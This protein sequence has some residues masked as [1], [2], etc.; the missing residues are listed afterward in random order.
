MKYG[1]LTIVEENIDYVMAK[2]DCGTTKSYKLGNLK[3]GHTKSCGCLN[4]E[5]QKEKRDNGV[6]KTRLYHIWQTMKARCSNPNSDRYKY[7]GARGISFCSE[8]KVFITFQKWAN[9]NG[10]SDNLTLDRTE[11]NSDYSPKNCRWVTLLVQ[12]RNKRNNIKYK[13]E[14]TTEASFRLGGGQ[15]MVSNRIKGKGWSIE[16]AFSTPNLRPNKKTI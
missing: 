6:H 11:V 15:G 16:R 2:C 9:E 13:G 8:W 12:S 4:L 3:N 1:R 7:Y 10:Y 14:T 5:R